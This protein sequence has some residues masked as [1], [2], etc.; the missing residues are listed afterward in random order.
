MGKDVPREYKEVLSQLSAMLVETE[1]FIPMLR[2]G[3]EREI[4]EVIKLAVNQFIQN[5]IKN[6]KVE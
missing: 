6:C 2:L 4:K 3:D 5:Y 1:D